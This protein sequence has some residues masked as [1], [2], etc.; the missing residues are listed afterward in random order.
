GVP[1]REGLAAFGEVGLT[2]RLRPA[3]QADR[4]V[5][6]CRKLGLA[7]VLA[8]IGTN[9]ATVE[10]ETLRAALAAGLGEKPA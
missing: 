5:E 3:T 4:R 6:E 8:P 10:A 1:V 2:G 9:G 7:T